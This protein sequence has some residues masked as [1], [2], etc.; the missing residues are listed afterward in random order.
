M[1]VQEYVVF[2]SC[3]YNRLC[4]FFLDIDFLLNSIIV[5]NHTWSDPS[6][7]KSVKMGFITQGIILESN[8][9]VLEMKV[10]SPDILHI[11]FWSICY[12]V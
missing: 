11:S 12:I 8:Q 9:Y 3:I 6:F 1:A 7:L 4:F 5:G 2:F 10:Y